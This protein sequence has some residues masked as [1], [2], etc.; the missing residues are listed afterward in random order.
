MDGLSKKVRD[1]I[2]AMNLEQ[3]RATLEQIWR[4]RKS[5]DMMA[6]LSPEMLQ[7]LTGLDTS[8]LRSMEDQA[9]KMTD[10]VTLKIRTSRL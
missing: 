1:T 3:K 2:D 5:L 8:T 9:V 7:E 6:L 10:M 4:V